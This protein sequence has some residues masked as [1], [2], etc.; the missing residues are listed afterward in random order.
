[1]PKISNDI[2]YL[3]IFID[4]KLNFD[5]FFKIIAKR[6]SYGIYSISQVKHFLPHKI[7]LQLY[8]CFVHSHLEFASYY[9]FSTSKKTQEYITR[10]Q[11]KAIRIISDTH[12]QAHTALHFKLL[13][14]LPI[15]Q[16]AIHN[17]VRFMSSSMIRKCF[18]QQWQKNGERN[19]QYEFRNS[20]E[21][22]ISRAKSKMVSC[23]P[24]IIYP[25][26]WNKFY[27]DFKNY[28]T[29][30]DNKPNLKSFLIDTYAKDHKC[31]ARNCFS[32]NLYE[33]KNKIKRNSLKAKRAKLK[34]IIKKKGLAK[35]KRYDKL[36]SR[37]ESDYNF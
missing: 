36:K 12:F 2:R 14:I 37:I 29:T 5:L 16:L 25:S 26:V 21:F 17:I 1:M 18:E 30:K 6:I 10:L 15:K 28:C 33:N 22:Y 3:G 34:S 19:I 23:S 24:F 13:N 32:C 4:R 20:N 9:F 27:Y 7:L 31:R 35:K 8:F 11:K